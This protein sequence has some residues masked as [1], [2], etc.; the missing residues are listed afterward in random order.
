MSAFSALWWHAIRRDRVTL[1]LWILGT[2]ALGAF[3]V[4]AS[5]DTYG[6]E[7]E[8]EQVLS[9]AIAS[10]AILV[11]R[12]TPNG[13]E[14]APFVFF[15]IFTSLAVMA[16][17]MSTFLA[18]RHTR[19]DEE[20]GRAELL[21]A[22][23]AGRVLPAAVALVHGLV[24]NVLL[25]ALTALGLLASGLP[26]DGSLVAG[27]ALAAVGVAFL[28]IGLAAAELVA[29][30]RGAN[31]IGVVAVLAAYVLR[32]I[33]DAAG[34]PSEDLQ[35]LAPAWP[36]FLSPIGYGQFTGA[37]AQN[38]LRPLLVPVAFAA[39]LVAGAF[40]VRAFRD[41]G[42]SLLPD[43]QGRATAGPVLSSSLGLVWRLSVS[44]LVAWSAGALLTGLLASSLT[45]LI[46]QLTGTEGVPAV[47]EALRSAL[48][49][50]ATIEQAFVA[51]FFSIGGILASCC[52]VQ[53]G[54]RARQ[55]ESRGTAE[56]VLA[57]PVG[58]VRWLAEYWLVG[59]IVIVVVLGAALLGGL[60]GAARSADAAALMPV[61]VQAAVAQLP[62]A[63]V[64]LGVALLL[65]AWLPVAAVGLSWG[66]VGVL[67]VLGVFGPLLQ[68]P[69]WV[70][71][72]SPFTHT[73]VAAGADTDWSGGFWL[74]G[75][76]LVAGV[77]AV[78]S[79]RRR[80]LAPGD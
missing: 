26:A 39:L 70:T 71:G 38:D 17:L 10:R 16:G 64:F 80:E 37:Y 18:V 47:L 58:R 54:I 27:L 53:I 43:R 2:A 32:G 51:V 66:L 1:P 19:A 77:L 7:A 57:T 20:R 12:G 13:A 50:T 74:L 63:L 40:V 34:T 67:S 61:V 60:L 3:A 8:R 31:T 62:A 46:D 9:L 79:M 5:E 48:G 4:A 78:A 56:T 45:A 42:A 25:G 36:S 23:R 75:I 28:G 55:E 69:E 52:A 44:T 76:A 29:T 14:F 59:A 73:P 11:F 24:A 49:G 41:Q 22:T 72:L 15:L 21:G 6:D 65:V 68:A 33:G 30:S 35:H